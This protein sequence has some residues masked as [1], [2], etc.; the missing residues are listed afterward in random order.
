MSSSAPAAREAFTT[1]D[2]TRA[3]RIARAEAL[4]EAAR[5]AEEDHTPAYSGTVSA[6]AADE[7]EW[8]AQSQR[9]AIAERIRFA[10]LNDGPPEA[11][12]EQD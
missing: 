6:R 11:P 1:D 2:L 3:M 7:I 9:R 5:I 12:K 4:A 10:A 8:V